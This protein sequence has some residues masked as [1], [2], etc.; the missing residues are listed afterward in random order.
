MGPRVPS[1]N[2]TEVALFKE[3]LEFLILVSVSGRSGDRGAYV[4]MHGS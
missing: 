2:C 1:I 3:G 4:G